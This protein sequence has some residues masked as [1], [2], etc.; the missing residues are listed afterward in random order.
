MDTR[1]ILLV[2]DDQDLTSS[3]GRYLSRIEHLEVRTENRGAEA[4]AAAR[5]FRPDLILLDIVMPDMD[6]NEVAAA[7]DADSELA[8]IPVVFLTGLITSDEVGS[9]HEV[10]GHRFLAKPIEP[11][12]LVKR[13][14]EFLG[15]TQPRTRQKVTEKA[16][17]QILNASLWRHE[18]CALCEF[19]G[20]LE[21]RDASGGLGPN[22]G[23]PK[24]TCQDGEVSE[25]CRRLADGVVKEAA[26]RYEVEW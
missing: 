25:E 20:G 8:D 19:W 16:L 1:R 15:E 6:G 26:A 12:T 3:L 17:L 23:P 13:I 24:L 9:H 14:D 18:R 7:L 10:G 4:L 5:D 21:Q 22:W 2:D 11:E